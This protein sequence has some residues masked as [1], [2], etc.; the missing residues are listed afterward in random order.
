MGAAGNCSRVR[1]IRLKIPTRKT[2]YG[3]GGNQRDA[4]PFSP[5]ASL[6]LPRAC[7]I[8]CLTN[9]DLGVRGVFPEEAWLVLRAFSFRLFCKWTRVTGESQALCFGPRSFTEC[10][11]PRPRSAA[12]TARAAV[13]RPQGPCSLSGAAQCLTAQSGVGVVRRGRSAGSP[14]S[15]VRRQRAEPHSLPDPTNLLSNNRLFNFPI[16]QLIIQLS[17]Q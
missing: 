16:T 15:C 9:K 6:S 5:V 3:Q 13:T 10:P 12:E 7:P 4:D 14:F 11:A 1:R 8:A 17:N 2:E